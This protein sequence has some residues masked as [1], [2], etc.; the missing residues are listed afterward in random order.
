VK[1]LE[2]YAY[3]WYCMPGIDHSWGKPAFFALVRLYNTLAF[4][5][6]DKYPELVKQKPIPRKDPAEWLY[7]VVDNEG[8]E[9]ILSP[10][11]LQ[12]M[13]EHI[14]EGKG[15]LGPDDIARIEKAGPPASDNAAKRKRA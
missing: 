7:M 9:S 14:Q 15:V 4:H 12:M 1:F 6:K 10:E 13:L 2:F 3:H 8:I 11:K 5:D